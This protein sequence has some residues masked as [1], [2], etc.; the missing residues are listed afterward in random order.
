MKRCISYLDTVTFYKVYS[1][2]YGASKLVESSGEVNCLF[3]QSTGYGHSNNQDFINSDA[4]CY[5]DP[6]NQFLIDNN[7]RL[8]GMYIL[9]PFFDVDNEYGWYKVTKVTVNRDLLIENKV[10]NIEL[11]LKKT[12]KLG[13]VS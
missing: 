3:S 12:S 11:A 8:E 13:M 6:E 7:Y 1:G 10:G 4:I 2:G 5:P 9:A